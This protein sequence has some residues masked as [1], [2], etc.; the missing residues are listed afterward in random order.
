MLRSVAEMERITE[1]FLHYARAGGIEELGDSDINELI[2]ECAGH[3]EMVGR[4]LVLDLQDIPPIRLHAPSIKRALNNLIENA[5]RYGA[6]EVA[7]ASRREKAM[8]R[9]SVLDRGPGVEPAEMEAIKRPFT[10]GAG[11]VGTSGAGLGLAIVERIA[12]VH[13]GCL[14]LLPRPGGGLEARI[15]L[16]LAAPEAIQ[17]DVRIRG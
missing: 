17:S 12:R 3:F 1:Q 16:P 8:A 14:D 11:S 6:G 10:R 9:L 7:V 13:G 4:P 5:L 15:G 2:R